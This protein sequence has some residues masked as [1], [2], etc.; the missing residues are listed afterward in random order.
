MRKRR[1]RR[2]EC[3]R[4]AKRGAGAVMA[5]FRTNKIAEESLSAFRT[6]SG[7]TLGELLAGQPVL[8]VF[9]RH[10]GCT[11]CREAVE[12]ISK[13]RATIET[14]GTRLAFVHLGT[15]E[16]ANSFFTS[17]GLEDAPRF[18]DPDGQL[19]EA[20]GLVRAELR[21]YLNQESILRML[22]AWLH[23]H[24]VGLPAGD[25]QRMPGAFLVKDGE[26]RKAFRH[27]LVSDRPDYLALAAAT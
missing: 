16:K 8:L 15:E 4:S 13:K 17:Y 12:D 5:I 19:Y 2:S 27:K 20:F 10:F 21:Q 23:G 14:E 22:V 6:Q 7:Q 1:G 18:A 3:Q 25:I 9:L 26:I 24:F 11:F